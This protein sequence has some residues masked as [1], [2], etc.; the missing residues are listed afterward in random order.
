[1]KRR[2]R[3]IS[4]LWTAL[5]LLTTATAAIAS[6]IPEMRGRWS[7][8]GSTTQNAADSFFD[9]FF[10]ITEQNHRRFSGEA[11]LLNRPPN[12]CVLP[13][14]G[15]MAENGALKLEG[16]GCD[17]LHFDAVGR[18]GAVNPGPPQ[19]QAL[20]FHLRGAGTREE[21]QMLLL[22]MEGGPNWQNPGPPEVSGTWPGAFRS[23]KGTPG[24]GDL[25]PGELTL[26]LRSVMAS[27]DLIGDSTP[28]SAFVGTALFRQP[29]PPQNES[30]FDVSFELK[31]TVGVLADD[32]QTVPFGAIGLERNPGP[33]QSPKISILIGLLRPPNPNRTLPA[34]QGRYAFVGSFFDVFASFFNVFFDVNGAGGVLDYGT[35]AVEG[36]RRRDLPSPNRTP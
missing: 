13:L 19:L 5:C 16:T 18:V 34:I 26:N 11:H 10:D 23:G 29:G 32:S 25:P 28:T 33:G 30:F 35:F 17:G 22:H 24:G 4:I 36:I 14:K 3:A 2:F 6:D 20:R 15:T 8:F 9:V 7:G 21:G 12:P 1:M 27:S 31:G